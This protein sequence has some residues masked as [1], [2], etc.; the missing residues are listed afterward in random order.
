MDIP[1]PRRILA[2]SLTDSAHHLIRVLKDLTGTTPEQTS[3]SLAGASHTLSLKTTYY[4]AEVPIWLDL[5][6]TPS[7]WSASF[8]SP[9]AKEVLEVLGGVIVVFALPVNPKSEEGKAAQDFIEQVGKV[10]KRGLGGWEWDGVGLC[11]GIGEIDNVDVWEDCCGEL[12]LEFVQVRSQT[13]ILRNEFGEKT[14]IPR[15]L[16]ALESNDWANVSADDLDLDFGDMDYDALDPRERS[17]E[18]LLKPN[19]KDSAEGNNASTS[20]DLDPKELDFGF[21][22]K[23]FEGLKRA[24]WNAGQDDEDLD[25][26]ESAHGKEE[27]KEEEEEEEEEEEDE[28][29]ESL[30]DNDI[31][32]VERMM[33]K[34][35]AVRDTSAGLPEEQRKRVAAKAV[36]EVM[37][38]L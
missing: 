27:G 20:T 24:I 16:E 32:K 19:H 25:N 7:E 35:Q 30:D 22:P 1:N 29:E 18:A 6:S 34:L 10:M 31:Q 17:E 26:G 9:E 5:I 38:E 8:L 12:G 33:A 4:T 23:D 11:L 3:T 37:K 15:A 21:D 36:A 28:E 13:K 2:V 14:G